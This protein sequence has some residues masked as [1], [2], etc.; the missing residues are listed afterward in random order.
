MELDYTTFYVVLGSLVIGALSGLMSIYIVFRNR[1]LIGDVISHAALPGIVLV[2][3]VFKTKEIYLLLLGAIIFSF[4]ALW[5]IRQIIIHKKIELDSA[6]AL[7]LSIFFGF[8]V[9]LLSYSQKIDVEQAGI[10]VFLFGQ[11]SSLVHS[12]LWIMLIIFFVISIIILLFWKELKL[13]SFDKEYM[14]SQKFPVKTM[15]FLLDGLLII[16]IVVGLKTVGVVLMAAMVI[17]PAAAARQWCSSFL[18]IAFLAIFFGGFAGVSGSFLSSLWK[19]TPTGPSII[20]VLTFLVIFS[21]FFASH[22]GLLGKWIKIHKKK[23][24]FLMQI[25]LQN[26]YA[27]SLQHKSQ[28]HAHSSKVI[29][30]MSNQTSLNKELETMENLGWIEHAEDT[31]WRLTEKGLQVVKQ[32]PFL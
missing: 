20:L 4:L 27:L 5:L 30:E 9:L 6:F 26:F 13:L 25:A 12:D 15:T 28:Y 18:G 3:L 29:A 22:R 8:G 14:A 31:N 11:A 32:K 17:A 7:T 23:N 10:Q 19:N 16:A 2:F 24:L 21:V 1:S